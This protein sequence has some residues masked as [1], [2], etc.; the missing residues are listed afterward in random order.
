MTRAVVYTDFLRH[1][2]H[3]PIPGLEW[4]HYPP[5]VIHGGVPYYYAGTVDETAFYYKRTQ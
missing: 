1:C 4:G 2:E 5:V 3:P